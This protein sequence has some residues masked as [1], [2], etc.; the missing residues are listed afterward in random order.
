M[1]DRV[2]VDANVVVYTLDADAPAHR[3]SL[4]FWRSVVAG[5]VESAVSPQVLHEAFVALTRRVARPLDPPTVAESLLGILQTPG[6]LLLRPGSAAVAEAL[7]LAAARGAR[8][9]AIYDIAHVAVM[10]EHG[11]RRI[12]TFNRRHFEGYEGIEPVEPAAE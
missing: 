4:R 2:Y 1:V 10:R 7:R 9:P 6:L 12:I 8:G 11:L 3:P 5:E